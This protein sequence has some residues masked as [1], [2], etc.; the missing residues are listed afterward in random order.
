MALDSFIKLFT[1]KD[2]KFYA[3]F[4]EQV[5]N[6]VIIAETMQKLVNSSN[7]QDL[8]DLE[9]EIERLEHVCD[10]STHKIFLELSKSFITPFDR[11]DIHKLASALD[12]IADYI[13]GA[14]KRMR[15]YKVEK[16]TPAMQK[17][18]DLIYQCT[19]ELQ[20]AVYELK[21]LKNIRLITDAC[22]RLNSIENHAD[23]IY[24]T[25]VG[26]LFEFEKDAI[27]L[28]KHKEILQALESATDMAEDAANVLESIIVKVS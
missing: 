11:E 22:V 24:D 4:N 19:I 10:Q 7:P 28:I 6:L 21:N 14:S 3:F 12:E 9:K 2:K 25:A 15:M 16:F 13:H 8:I 23:D 27:T 26:D 20:K 1:P 17:L 5:D 18:A